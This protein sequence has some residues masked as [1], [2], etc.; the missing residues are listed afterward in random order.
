[1]ADRKVRDRQGNMVDAPEDLP[2]LALEDK[3]VRLS[4]DRAL[5]NL[6]VVYG[7]VAIDFSREICDDKLVYNALEVFAFC[8]RL[9][10]SLESI[11]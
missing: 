4:R 3:G 2:I 5:E 1:M 7:S 11:G 10:K 6:R 9:A 8:V